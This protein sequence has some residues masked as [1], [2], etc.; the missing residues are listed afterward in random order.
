MKIS[1]RD[2]IRYRD[3]MAKISRQAAGDFEKH[4]KGKEL[5]SSREEVIAYAAALVEKYSDV[6]SELACQMYER[7]AELSGVDIPPAVPAEAAGFGEVAKGIN[8][9]LKQSPAGKLC[10]DVVDRLVKRAGADTMLQNAKRDGVQFAWVPSG[11]TCPFCMMLASR[12]WQYISA[13]SLKNGHAEHIHA[14]C[15][16]QYAVRFDARTTIEGYDPDKYLQMY[17]NA[18]GNTWQEKLNAMRREKQNNEN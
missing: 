16:C 18:E 6:S 4:F 10:S 5:S 15:D 14:H 13:K 9:T 12:G 8:G 3:L 7:I 11:D 17:E 1:K 2:W